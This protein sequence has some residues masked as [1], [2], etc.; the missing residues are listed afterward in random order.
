MRELMIYITIQLIGYLISFFMIPNFKSYLLKADL[1][2][3]DIN[4][5]NTEAGKVK[6]PETAGLIPATI[7]LI[8]MMIGNYQLIWKD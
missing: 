1:F 3:Y 5:K 8:F 4:K 6:V 2:G 7:Y